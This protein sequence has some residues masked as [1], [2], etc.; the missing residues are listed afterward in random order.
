MSWLS[1]IL[2]FLLVTYSI[3]GFIFYHR[4]MKKKHELEVKQKEEEILKSYISTIE[5]QQVE[6]RKFHHD[7]KNIFLSL[8]SFILDQEYEELENYYYTKIKPIS[9]KAIANKF[10]L[11]HLSRINIR[12]VK[13]ILASKLVQAHQLGID[14]KFE[15]P[16]I[17]ET[18]PMDSLVFVRVVG[19]ILDNAIEELET[20]GE[21]QL[22]VG[23]I[24]EK[25]KDFIDFIVQNTC[26]TDIQ[27]LQILKQ[28]GFSSKAKGRG[29]G[30]ANLS[31][32]IR[33]NKNA[34]LITRI[35]ENQFIQR[36]TVGGQQE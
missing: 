21:G 5:E 10:Q 1:Q 6:I 19:I 25:D 35:N 13:S 28:P 24:K 20:L 12:E 8:E 9:D 18:L 4:Y 17:I 15:A 2:I 3:V 32:L 23:L 26:R 27:N 31:E 30:L 11:E 33:D 36:I 16:E 7:Y 22:L 29:L 14:V 34:T